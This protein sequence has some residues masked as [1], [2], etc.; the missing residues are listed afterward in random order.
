VI[1]LKSLFLTPRVARCFWV[2]LVVSWA[3]C[4]NSPRGLDSGIRS[5]IATPETPSAKIPTSLPEAPSVKLGAP[6]AADDAAALE[7]DEVL[8][9]VD[10]HFPLLLAIEQERD[11]AAGNRLAATG[12]FDLNVK[13]RGIVQDGT[14]ENQRLD[15]LAEQPLLLGGVNLFSGYRFGYGDYPVYY[16]D[17]KTADGG[18]FRAGVQ[19]PLLRDSAIDRRRAA[20]RQARIVEQMAEPTIQRARIDYLRNAA[21]VY[22]NWAAA[23][24]QYAIASA[25]LN[26]ARDR[27][28]GFEEQFKRGQIAE[29]VVIDNRR[30]IVERDGVL[31]ASERRLQQAALEL[32]LFYRDPEGN[33]VVPESRRLPAINPDTVTSPPKELAADIEE[34]LRQR[35]ELARFRLMKERIAVDQQL[36]E[37]QLNPTLNA[38]LAG[39]QDVG[40]GKKG[41]GIFALDRS[42][43]EAA[44]VMEVPLQRRDASGKIQTARA[45]MAQVA[46]QERF[47]RDQV[48]AEVQ[49]ATSNLDRA[50]ER[51]LLARQEAKIAQQVADLERARFEKGQGTLLEVNLRE[52][53]AA[54]AQAKVIDTFA[55]VRRAQADLRAAMGRDAAAPGPRR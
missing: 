21:K 51:L 2:G 11:I 4:V 13:S 5:S 12:A 34:A 40:L 49:D 8:A 46:A 1:P 35:P 39:A 25:L 54:G 55:E 27:Q 45:N 23:G 53:A 16:G 14:F 7:L 47:A 15:F 10:S 18:E 30:L 24:R 29:F 19:V 43:Y 20:L 26:L 31:V 36:A 52:L 38:V 44:L 37:N 22:W 6:Q 17:R 50:F 9:S 28:A 3:G 33:P 32:S 42:N 41:D 48:V